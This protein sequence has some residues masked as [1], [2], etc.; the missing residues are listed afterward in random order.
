LTFKQV[1]KE[2]VPAKAAG[3]FSWHLPGTYGQFAQKNALIPC[4][5]F[6]FQA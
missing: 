1:A 5:V 2:K 6:C 3:T 4:G